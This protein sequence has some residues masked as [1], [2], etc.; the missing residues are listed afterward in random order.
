MQ[1]SPVRGSSTASPRRATT[2]PTTPGSCAKTRSLECAECI[3]EMMSGL[4][5]KLNARMK[6]D[7]DDKKFGGEGVF[8]LIGDQVDSDLP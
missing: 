5:D 8:A 7:F 4:R 6:E 1:P 2:R 3:K